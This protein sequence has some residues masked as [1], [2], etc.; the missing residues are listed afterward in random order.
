MEFYILNKML[1]H[2]LYVR[3]NQILLLFLYVFYLHIVYKT[4]LL[5]NEKLYNLAYTILI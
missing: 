1:F 5:V 4:S 2:Q 3:V